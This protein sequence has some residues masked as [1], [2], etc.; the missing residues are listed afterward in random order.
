MIRII[1]LAALLVPAA[2]LRA[3]VTPEQALQIARQAAIQANPALNSPATKVAKNQ[4]DDVIA[5]EVSDPYQLNGEVF[6]KT[7]TFY[8]CTKFPAVAQYT[9]LGTKVH[10]TAASSPMP[11]AVIF[12]R[13][14][15][16]VSPRCSI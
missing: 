3:D 9:G 14:L 13:W 7:F 5:L 16:I 6:W 1:I 11:A 15:G 4:T 8:E 10:A 12:Y 2:T